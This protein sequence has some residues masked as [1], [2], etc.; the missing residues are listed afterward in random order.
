MRQSEPSALLFALPI[1]FILIIITLVIVATLFLTN[2][3]GLSRPILETTT[4]TSR[5]TPA[6]MLEAAATPELLGTTSFQSAALGFEWQYP[7]N[8]RKREY[9]LKAVFSPSPDGLTPNELGDRAIWA[10]IPAGNTLD[11]GEILQA[12][13]ANFSP[14]V[15]IADQR[16]ITLAGES[17]TMVNFSFEGQNFGEKGRG[18]AAAANKNEVGYYF[19]AAAP[20]SEWNAADPI[21]QQIINT[22]RFTEEAVLR[23]TDATPPPTPTPTPTPVVY[24]VQSGDTLLGI[25]LEYGVEADTLAA[26]NGIEDP[27]NLRTGQRL[28]IP[29][30]RR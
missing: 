10:G 6:L 25:A 27:R 21:F 12:V 1:I 9:T 15:D 4:P 29:L 8:W 11:H 22:F 20:A 30:R 3:F 17:W 5:P 24:I 7:A 16:N 28:I 19:V 26:R 2:F 18:I 23:P 14:G 13:L